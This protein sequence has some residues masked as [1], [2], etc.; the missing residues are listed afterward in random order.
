F[1]HALSGRS[2]YM[3][4]FQALGLSQRIAHERL[5]RICFIDY[6]REMALVAERKDSGAGADQIVAVARLSKLRGTN[7][8]E[9]A[10]LVADQFQRFGLGTELLGRLLQVGRDEKLQRIVAEILPENVDMQRLCQRFGFELQS[11][12]G[13][14]TVRA[15]IGL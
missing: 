3:R 15:T 10:M 9:L 7:E 6:D 12:I 1:H 13:D 11:S 2:V 14:P 8:A 4:Y 5:T